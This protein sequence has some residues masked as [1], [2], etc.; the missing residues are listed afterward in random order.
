MKN[1]E[2]GDEDEEDVVG[3]V[4]VFEVRHV[5]TLGGVFGDEERSVPSAAHVRVTG[6]PCASTDVTDTLPSTLTA[7]SHNG[8]NAGFIWDKILTRQC[9]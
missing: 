4:W 3:D 2:D 7:S 8:A 1:D 5:L 9:A 6:S